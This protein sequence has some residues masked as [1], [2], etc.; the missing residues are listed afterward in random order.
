MKVREFLESLSP[1]EI[2]AGNRKQ[3]ATNDQVYKEFVAAY[4]EGRCSLCGGD[5]DSFEPEK[6]CY[7]WFLKP[8][9]LRKKNFKKYL[10]KPIGLF[11]LDSYFK[12][13]ANLD[14]PIRNVNDLTDVNSSKI[15]EYTARY[16]DIEWSVSLSKSDRDGHTNAKYGSFPHFHL[17]MRVKDKI[18]IKFNDFHVPLTNEDLWTLEALETAPEKIIHETSRGAGLSVLESG[19]NLDIIDEFSLRTENEAEAA[20]NVESFIMMPEG[21]TMSGDDLA[22][23]FKESH[24]TK[25]P[26]RHLLREAYPEASI[27]SHFS[28]GPGAVEKKVRNNRGGS[29]N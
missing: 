15:I 14:A 24:N 27:E 10:K 20:F 13:M 28:P 7:H 9:G 21:E 19:E 22:D 6:E 18:F 23:L 8:G 4:K 5:L 12:W 1:E 25:K 3:Q 11:R 2:E 17:Q 26:L 29:K 16:K